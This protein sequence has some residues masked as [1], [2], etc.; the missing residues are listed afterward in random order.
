MK[1]AGDNQALSALLLEVAAELQAL[2]ARD[3]LA[4]ESPNRLAGF[5]AILEKL[6]TTG[7]LLHQW[8]RGEKE[9]QWQ[10]RLARRVQQASLPDAAPILQGYT[11]GG[12]TFSAEEVGGD[13]LDFLTLEDGS[14]GIAI[15]DASG[16]GIS[17]ALLIT[18]VCAYL[19]ALA[20]SQRSVARIVT[21]TNRRVE[22]DVPEGHFVTLLLAQLHLERGVVIYSSAG[23]PSGY[24]L[25]R[26]GA[27]RRTLPSTGMPLGLQL[28][29]EFPLGDTIMIEPGE[30]ILLYTDGIVEATHPE[31]GQFGIQRVLDVV[32]AK[33]TVHPDA[34]VKALLEAARAHALDQPGDDMT[35]I[36]LKAEARY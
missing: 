25:D 18:Q 6:K 12:G 24:V 31:L 32:R 22:R 16:H 35:A 34:I 17:A 33:R 29:G 1:P 11:I 14:L 10:A 26:H 3:G 23:H 21:L 20:L 36:V 30:M 13:F 4:A 2:L 15:G 19:R 8:E 28:R 7:A 27:V 5:N 9:R